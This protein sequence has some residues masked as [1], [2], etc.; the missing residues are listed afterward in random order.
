MLSNNKLPMLIFAVS[1]YLTMIVSAHQEVPIQ[2]VNGEL[3]NLHKYFSPAEFS[4]AEKRFVIAGKVLVIPK[5]ISQRLS[6]IITS[7]TAEQEDKKQLPSR[8]SIKFL[9]S[10]SHG[11]SMTPPY[12]VMKIAPRGENFI[13]ELYV[14]LVDVSI[15]KSHVLITKKNNDVIYFPV[16]VD[17]DKSRVSEDWQSMI[18]IWRSGD[19]VFRITKNYIEV[20]TG[21]VIMDYPK[22]KI[23]PEEPGM[24]ILTSPSGK[25]ERFF[26]NVIGD[27]LELSFERSAGIE[28]A[29]KGSKSDEL[30]RK[31]AEIE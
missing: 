16:E 27:N 24:M 30:W 12:L 6:D 22:G 14:D 18:G 31:L 2:Y 10:W 8:Y 9:A 11:P 28:L 17:G 25:T 1:I 3:V 13:F 7:G 19:S 29:R 4:M 20:K 23:S 21:G 26:Y 15:M 5:D